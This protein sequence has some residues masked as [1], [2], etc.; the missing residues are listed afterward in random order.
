LPGMRRRRTG[1]I[2]N[3]TSVGGKISVAHLLPY[4]V[5]KF[6]SV[7]LSEGLRS[8]LVRDGVYVT[9][10]CPGLMRT[11]S[12]RHAWF[13]GQHR[14]EYAWFSISDSLP[15]VTI[16]ATRAARRILDACRHGDAELVLPLSTALAVKLHALFPG[17]SANVLG[18]VDRLLPGPNGIGTVMR[19][20][21]ES[22]S[23]W[24]PS[25]LTALGNQ[26][27]ARNNELAT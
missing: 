17:V 14:A 8:A 5:S 10:V 24:S 16:A 4:S 13:K 1:R 7:G 27:A 20:G 12:P 26:A 6:A 25:V 9:T 23:R 21:S 19:R 11:G 2:V 3:I 15:V 18:L 22:E